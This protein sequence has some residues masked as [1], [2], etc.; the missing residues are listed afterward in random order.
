MLEQH[1]YQLDL[2]IPQK[3]TKLNREQK[4]AKEMFELRLVLIRLIVLINLEI[5]MVW[6]WLKLRCYV[7]RPLNNMLSQVRTT[8]LPT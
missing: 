2:K 5:S 8:L 3:I 4:L 1:L 7:R 6:I